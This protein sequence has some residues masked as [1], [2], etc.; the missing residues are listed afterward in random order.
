MQVPLLALLPP[1]PLPLL[2]LLLPLLLHARLLLPGPAPL[3]L[4]LPTFGHAGSCWWPNRWL[5]QAAWRL[6]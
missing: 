2:L 4:L 6:G 5:P 3:P 1:R